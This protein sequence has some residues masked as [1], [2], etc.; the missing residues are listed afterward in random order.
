MVFLSYKSRIYYI[1]F[2]ASWDVKTLMLNMSELHK[3]EIGPYDSYEF[4]HRFPWWWWGGAL[5]QH[6]L[7]LEKLPQTQ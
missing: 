3:M 2:F 1:H 5:F 4:P 6:G 7:P